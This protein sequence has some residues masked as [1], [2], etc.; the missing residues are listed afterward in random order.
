[1]YVVWYE[2]INMLTGLLASF[3]I[4]CKTLNYTASSA[5][6]T[7]SVLWCVLLTLIVAVMPSWIPSLIIQLIYCSASI[8]FILV[9]TKIKLNTIIAAFLLSFGIGYVLYYVASF[10]ILFISMPF[11]SSEHIVGT[12]I[13][14]NTPFFLLSYS[15]VSALQLFLSFMLFRI[16]RFKKGFPFLLKGYA[17]IIALI[18]AGIVLVFATWIKVLTA[19]ED[20]TAAYLYLVGVFIIGVGIYIWIKRGIRIFYRKKQEERG[21]EIL[22]RELADYKEENRRLTEQNDALRIAN[23]KTQHRLAALER[24][25]ISMSGGSMEVSEELAIT[26]EDIKR[27]A[28]SYQADIGRLEGKN[29]LPSTKIKM[30]DD[31]FRDF[32][33]RLSASKIDFKLKVNGSIPYMVGEV[34]EQGKLETMIGDHLQNA[35]IAV[36][37]SD[38]AFRSVWAIIGLAVDCYELSVYDSGVPFD[39]DTLVR[40]GKER[41]TTHAGNGGSGI[42]FMT[43]FEVARECNAS[44]VVSE[45]IPSATD[46][47]KSVTIRFDGKSQYIIET[48]RPGDFPES[49]RFVVIAVNG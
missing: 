25:V 1:M 33:S 13:D 23:H 45:K 26:L 35:L 48:Y 20:A 30:L 43:T 31:L 2:A 15:L 41:V 8:I 24:A 14:Y 37:A 42:G 17:I 36:N 40:L 16:K 4:F 49:D 39:V 3:Y 9:L 6:K 46:Y 32:S 12:A 38:N 5:H 10:I 47:T 11:A 34:V 28:Q 18:S 21:I 29:T 27:A 7:L 44:L 22:E 19:S